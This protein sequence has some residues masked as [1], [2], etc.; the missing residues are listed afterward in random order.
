MQLAATVAFAAAVLSAAGLVYRVTAW[1]LD[2]PVLRRAIRN[3]RFNRATCA[4]LGGVLLATL[5]H[6][7]L[8]AP[9]QA[10]G[11]S[12]FFGGMIFLFGGAGVLFLD[13]VIE[14][15]RDIC[16]TFTAGRR[17]HGPFEPWTEPQPRPAAGNCLPRPRACTADLRCGALPRPCDS[18]VLSNP[19]RPADWRRT[20]QRR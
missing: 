18:G 4:G 6:V 3:R 12:V 10:S 16:A 15:L 5:A 8:L 17:A 9:H 7:C 2:S 1:S 14:D 13:L 11:A 20:G 19:W